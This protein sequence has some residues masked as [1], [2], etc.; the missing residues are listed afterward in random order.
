MRPSSVCVRAASALLVAAIPIR[1]QS[2]AP[3]ATIARTVD[4][5][6][7]DFVATHGAPA[8][9]IGV[10]RGGDTLA[11]GGWGKA[12]I[13]NDVAATPRSVYRIG[14]ITKQF[15]SAAVMKLVEGGTVK[16][17][18]SIGTYLPALPA[19]WRGVTVKELLNHTSGIPSYTDVGPRWQRRWGEEMTPD[20]LVALT[21]NDPMWF[22]AGSSWRY[23]NSGYV[24]LGMLIEKVVG[25]PWAQE[26]NER[27]AK[28]LGLPDTRNCPTG[29]IIMRRASGYEPGPNGTFTNSVY[30]AMSQPYAAGAMCSTVVDLGRW[31][32]ALATGKVV[33]PESYKL[34]TTPTGAA[35][36]AKYGFGLGRDTMATHTVISHGGGIPGFITAN[37][38]FPDEDISITVL[39]NSGAA[40]SDRLLAQVARATFGVPL[41]RQPPRVAISAADRARYVGVYALQL[42]GTPRDFTIFEK[43]GELYS[44]LQ[45]QG[46]IAL[47]PFGNHVFGVDFD[48]DL[49]VTFTVE[50]GKATK[51]ALLQNGRTSEGVR[52]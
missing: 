47:I 28:P 9:S 4:S 7:K 21:A 32:R 34:M 12:D 3:K 38:Y 20:T 52:K 37:A 45:G 44:Q 46:P 33:S 5:L 51:M 41:K 2:V 10:F 17:D 14:S 25:H 39:T 29:D 49:R 31:N 36:T 40:R 30:L 24:V 8:V 43:D 13:E 11:L 19:A 18:D 15:T 27:F 26:I 48:P 22:K 50:N 35:T 1:A 23:D 6:A 42:G 16:L